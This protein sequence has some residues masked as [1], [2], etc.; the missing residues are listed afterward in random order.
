[1]PSQR[2]ARFASTALLR[3]TKKIKVKIK[4]KIKIKIKVNGDGQSLP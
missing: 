1:L 4:V 3:I 2:V